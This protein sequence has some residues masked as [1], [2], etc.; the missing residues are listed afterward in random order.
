MPLAG[1]AAAGQGSG[2]AQGGSGQQVNPAD[3]VATLV[4]EKA[5][6]EVKPKGEDALVPATDGQQLRVGDTVRT[7]T[8]GSRRGH[9]S[10]DG[11]HAS[12]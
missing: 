2:S 3:A 9:Y 1:A 5:N 10:D 11:S 6:V 4:V 8:T 12:T 7:D